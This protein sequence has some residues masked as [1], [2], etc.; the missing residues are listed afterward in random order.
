MTCRRPGADVEML[1]AALKIA[2][3]R[4]EVIQQDVMTRDSVDWVSN[5]TADLTVHSIIQRTDRMSKVD[6]TL[7]INYLVYGYL[8]KEVDDVQ[9][10]DFIV[11]SIELTMYPIILLAFALSALLM[12]LLSGNRTKPRFYDWCMHCIMVLLKQ[13]SLKER[14]DQKTAII[15]ASW[16]WFCFFFIIFYESSMKSTMTLTA[17]KGYIFNNLNGVLD[18]VELHGWSILGDKS[19]YDPAVFCR[20]DVHDCTGRIDKLRPKFLPKES[21]NA[22]DVI[23][24]LAANPKAIFFSGIQTDILRED[25]VYYDRSRRVLFIRDVGLP[26]E[27]LAFAVNKKAGNVCRRLNDA[28]GSMQSSYSN[29]AGRARLGVVAFVG[30]HFSQISVIQP[31]P[32]LYLSLPGI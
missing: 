18:A 6:F 27:M 14:F 28:I 5:G 17:K 20:N 8:V 15:V 30:D 4:A 10:E 23:Q 16:T 32:R 11:R 21:F 26:T 29:F 7:P 9:I 25:V 31:E 13:P 12:C 22:S 2:G 24:I 19:S 3:L 1:N